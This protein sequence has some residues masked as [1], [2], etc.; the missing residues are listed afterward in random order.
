[1]AWWPRKPRLRSLVVGSCIALVL[2]VACMR[3]KSDSEALY[4]PPPP[5]GAYPVQAAAP[6]EKPAPM[7]DGVAGLLGRS[8]KGGGGRAQ[9]RGSAKSRARDEDDVD[10]LADSPADPS[11]TAPAKRMVHYDGSVRLRVTDTRK[12]L[13]EAATMATAMGGFVEQQNETMVMLR[14]PVEHIREAFQKMLGMGDVLSKSLSAADITDAFT[15]IEL[16]LKTMRASR[17]RLIVLLASVKNEEER[18][19]ILG[20]IRRLTE[21]IDGLDLQVKTLA[22]LAAY[23]R[24]TLEVQPRET[25]GTTKADALAA[26]RWIDELSPFRRDTAQRGG[27][28]RLKAPAEMVVL[29]ETSHWI[30]E[31]ADGAVVWTSKRK[32]APKGSDEF[33]ASAIAERMSPDFAETTREKI[34]AFEFVK[35]VDGGT[36]H[37]SYMVG[38][39]ADGDDLQV[40]EIY[41]PTPEHEKR[42]STGVNVVISGGQS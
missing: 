28:F 4:E 21:E 3:S 13:D 35:F 6:M 10:A 36:T 38:V 8:G 18:L 42:Y 40:I 22:K 16:R 11:T 2:G 12:V 41:Y 14:V 37:Y 5:P 15:A 24:L 7:A 29:D 20:E 39:H 17:D 1:M 9:D 25:R 23:S 30:A 26:F 31:S 27:L 32:N 34:G 33:W 19:Q